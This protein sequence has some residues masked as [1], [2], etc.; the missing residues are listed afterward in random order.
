M[1]TESSKKLTTI[2]GHHLLYSALPVVFVGEAHFSILDGFNAVVRD[3][4]AVR[5]PSKIFNHL[6]GSCERLLGIHNPIAFVET[7]DE[8]LSERDIFLTTK[9]LEHVHKLSPEYYTHH[10]TGKEKLSL[11]GREPPVSGLGDSATGNDTMHM[12]MQP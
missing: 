2:K 9:S 11:A 3:G 6:L 8:V 4:D 10:F 5:I 7:V 1:Q 12:R